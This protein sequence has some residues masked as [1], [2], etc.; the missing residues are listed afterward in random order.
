SARCIG[1]GVIA[2]TV[3]AAQFLGDVRKRLGQ[4]FRVVGLIQS[5]TRLIG[6]RVQ[7]MVGAIVIGLGRTGYRRAAVRNRRVVGLRL[8]AGAEQTS[9]R[10]R[11]DHGAVAD[12]LHGIQIVARVVLNWIDERVELLYFAQSAEVGGLL[13]R[14]IDAV[15][16]ENDGF[17]PLNLV[18]PF[19]DCQVH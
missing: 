16:K 10:G 2:E 15:G 12:A 13:A 8:R 18:E 6:Q 1:F 11:H 9:S 7:V 3:L 4:L 5:A 17:S 19:S 14:S